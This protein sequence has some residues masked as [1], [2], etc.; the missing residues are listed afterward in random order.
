MTE[1]APRGWRAGSG[2]RVAAPGRMLLL[3]FLAD[4]KRPVTAAEIGAHFDIKRRAAADALAGRLARMRDSG[5]MLQD[6]KGRY[7]L[8]REMALIAGRVVGHANGYGFVIPDDGGG[9]LFLHHRQMRKVLHGDRVL[10]RLKDIDARGRREGAVVEVMVDPQREIVGHFHMES[11]IGFVEPDDPRFARDITIPGGRQGAATDGDIVAARIIRHPAG[12]QHAVGEVVEVL[13]RQQQPGMKT[14]IAIRKHGIPARWPAEVRAELNS[15][16]AR[17]QSVQLET[18]P[19]PAP[20]VDAEQRVD[21]RD[22]PLVTID[23]EDARDFDDAVYGEP[24]GGGDG[25]GDGNSAGGDGDGDSASG[26]GNSNSD[27]NPRGWRLVVAIADVGHYVAAGGALDTEALKRGNSVYFP[28][29]VVPMLP[30]QL[31][32]GICSLNPGADRHCMVCDMRVSRRGDITAYQFYPALMHSK[33]RLT[34]GAVADIVAGR[35]GDGGDGD[36]DGRGRD[37]DNPARRKWKEVAPHLDCLHAIA[38]ALGAQRKKR[39]SI[40]FDFPEAFIEFDEAQKI[41]RISQRERNPAHRLIE[42]CMLAANGCAARFLQQRFGGHGRGPGGRAIFRNHYGPDA[43]AL[44]NL[45]RALDGLGL[46]L[47]GGEAPRAGDY[48]ALVDAV[49]GR[50]AAPVVQL[51]LLR[52]LSQA[53]YATDPAGHF[54]LAEPVYTHF[55]SPI[56]R[57]SDLVVHRQIRQLLRRGKRKPRQ[58]VAPRGVSLEKVAE[59]CSSTERRAEDASRDVMAW[60]KAE[61]MQDKIGAEFDG[62]VSGVAAFGVFVQLRELFVDGLVHVTGLGDDYFLF[63][64]LR[65]RLTGQRGGRSFQLGD[66]LR[67]RLAAVSLDSGKIDFEL[68]GVDARPAPMRWKKP[69]KK[70]R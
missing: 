32:N 22:M 51:L 50:E 33:A 34:Y 47:G 61:F 64:P 66:A 28:N 62:T 17:L 6:R 44:A 56:R 25:D 59:Q 3:D 57:Y 70:R 58:L 11:G 10:A 38:R 21:L 35:D 9:D 20:G 18:E 19:E 4:S 54:A 69:G 2:S 48:A 24:L 67:V 27:S 16:K 49:A 13:G 31:S 43:D 26:D 45:R 53:E 8:P 36:G 39:G 29:R 14:D 5:L 42:E 1:D 40:D 63:D 65:L 23:G 30:P 60:L 55:T 7:A 46:K 41:R 12:H 52:S 68:C 15:M 37:G